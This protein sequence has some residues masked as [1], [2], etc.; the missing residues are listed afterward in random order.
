V[1]VLVLWWRCR[2]GWLHLLTRLVIVLGWHVVFI[3]LVSGLAAK[4]EICSELAAACVLGRIGCRYWRDLRHSLRSGTL[5]DVEIVRHVGELLEGDMGLDNG[6]GSWLAH[7]V[8]VVV[9]VSDDG[10]VLDLS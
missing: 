3:M 6:L 4:F 8:V 1:G 9:V 10:G 7:V 2:H 5:I